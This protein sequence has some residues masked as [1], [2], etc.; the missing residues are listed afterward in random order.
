MVRAW[1][2]VVLWSCNLHT[3]Y[4]NGV[5]YTNSIG[6]LLCPGV[7]LSP[8]RIMLHSTRYQVQ[9]ALHTAGAIVRIIDNT[10]RQ[11]R[12][13]YRHSILWNTE[14]YRNRIPVFV[15]GIPENSGKNTAFRL[16]ESKIIINNQTFSNLSSLL[17]SQRWSDI[18]V[19]QY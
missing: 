16:P 5:A 14:K 18:P 9:L 2:L 11:S 13:I 19:Q 8:I 6:I 17:S 3:P 15:S 10:T 1:P 12:Y 4:T 7:F